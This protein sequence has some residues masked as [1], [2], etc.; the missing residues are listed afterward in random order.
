VSDRLST[1]RRVLAEEVA[2]ALQLIT[3]AEG[4]IS[5]EEARLAEIIKKTFD[6]VESAAENCR[7]HLT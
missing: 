1:T 2:P 3:Q 7:S 4:L 6:R 5:T